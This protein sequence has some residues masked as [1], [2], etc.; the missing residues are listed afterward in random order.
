MPTE[1]N[2]ETEEEQNEL[3][4]KELFYLCVAKWQWF[5]LSLALCLGVAIVYLL[6]TPNVYTRSSSILIKQTSKN[7]SVSDEMVSFANLG[8]FS[9]NTN[10]N[11]EMGTLQ[12][13]DLMREVVERLHLDINYYVDGTFHKNALYGDNLPV[14]VTFAN[15]N[16]SVPAS[17]DLQYFKD[18][19]VTLSDF[20]KKG[21]SMGDAP[22]S[23][24]V[25]K[26]IQTPLGKIVVKRTT[27]KSSEV[28]DGTTIHVRKSV[29]QKAVSG[30]NAKL[31]VDQSDNK[32][33]IIDLAIKDVS[34]QRAEDVLNT[35]ISVY[36]ESWVK[37]KNQI[38]ISTSD[39]IRE[40][41]GVIEGELGNV[42]NDI[43]SYKSA[44][45]V[46]DVQAAANMYMSQANKAS[47]MVGELN[48]QAY[49]ARYIRNY[50][51]SETNKFQLLPVNSGIDNA[52]LASQINEYNTKLLD[53]NNLVS[54]SSVQNPIVVELDNSLN[55]LRNALV[56]S[57]DNELISLNEQIRSQ[58][59][60]SGA[61]TSKIASN[62]KQSKY[63]LSVERQQKV[64]ESLY[65]YLLQKRE[66]N[67]LSQAFTAYDTRIIAR[68][69]GS[70]TPSGPASK[71]ILLIAFAL[72]LLIPLGII[73]ALE[74]MNTTVRGR[75]D[76]EGLTLPFIGEIPLCEKTSKNPL[77]KLAK[78]QPDVQR[79][80]VKQGSHNAANEAFRVARTNLEF[81]TDA[82][83]R[84]SV[85][86][87]TSFNSGSGKSFFTMNMGICLAIKGKRVLVVDGDLRH[88]STSQY[89][90][91]PKPGLSDWLGERVDSIDDVIVKYEQQD[92][93]YVLPMGTVPPNPTELL[94]G[95]RLEQIIEAA[96]GRF[97]CILVDCPPVEL[98]ADAQILNK[99]ADRTV[100][101]VRARLLERDMLG[102]LQ[103]MYDEKKYKNM[104]ILLNG[105]ESTGSR[106]GYHYGYS[107]NYNE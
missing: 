56:R 45:L 89:V 36:N 25:G 105:T 99:Y 41:L 97:D 18:G 28:E 24:Q 2:F 90:G 13:P 106:Y 86:A 53:R 64:K 62:P 61:A 92:G 38:A 76:L 37:D 96:R 91:S 52:A 34:P 27:A 81:M 50:L 84:S 4:L 73:Y 74:S 70:M 47:E 85:V 51:T 19:R 107:Y 98:V 78:K 63:L 55:G 17:L 40:R 66:E 23:G 58:Q 46:P 94:L 26:A 31:S 100:F 65:L 11:N 93:L 102:T 95:K 43:S 9:T 7:K 35:L 10:V 71:K 83:E 59:G 80:V 101:V 5:A 44:N 68:P 104:S 22:V 77:R 8:M 21:E 49:M 87:V 57:I 15:L 3:N 82:D 54:Q 29:L 42:D 67:E 14:S 79:V 1:K 12:S 39:F 30:Y 103:T 33:S 88:G 20:R 6:R 32:S 16:A 48:N 60:R 72:G 69:S 75:K